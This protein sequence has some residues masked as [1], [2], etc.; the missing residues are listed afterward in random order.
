MN[1]QADSFHIYGKD[2]GDFEK[3]F[4]ER[5]AQPFET[6]VYNFHDGVVHEIYREAEAGIAEK[7]REYDRLHP[8]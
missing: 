3:R 5:S 2:I 1:W 8:E 4:I 6:R 7:I